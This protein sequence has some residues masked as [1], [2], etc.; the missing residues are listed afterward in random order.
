MNTFYIHALGCKVNS[1]EIEAIKDDLL[2][3]LP[4]FFHGYINK[5]T[6]NSE[7]PSPYS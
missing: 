4:K 7:Y 1:Y 3:F 6:I 5:G 2:E